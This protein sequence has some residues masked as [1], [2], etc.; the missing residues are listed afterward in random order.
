MWPFSLSFHDDI[1]G[2]TSEMY[3]LLQVPVKIQFENTPIFPTG[4]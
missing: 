3:H 4:L 1:G 2:N